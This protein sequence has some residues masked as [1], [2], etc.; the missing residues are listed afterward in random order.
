M[1][2][3]VAALALLVATATASALPPP[4]V[5]QDGVRINVSMRAHVCT[6]EITNVDA[7]PITHFEIDAK[8][9]YNH[10]GPEG[11]AL[12][13]EGDYHLVCRT[14]AARWAIHPGQTGEFSVRVASAS[15]SMGTASALV[16]FDG[17]AD[18]VR[19]ESVWAPIRHPRSFLVMTG[20][21][22]S[23]IAILHGL[24][25]ARS[26]RRAAARA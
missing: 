10:L 23:A 7:P 13:V 16:A 15:A 12:E 20:I 1:P 5:E 26:Q 2:A 4:R 9:T 24:F 18:P 22:I 17:S 11:W 8:N 6:Y 14:D 19:F 3:P 25:I 21:V